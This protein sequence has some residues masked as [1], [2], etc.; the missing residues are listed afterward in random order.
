MDTLEQALEDL[1]LWSTPGRRAELL[2]AAWRSGETNIRTL[3]EAARVT[4]QTVYTDLESCGI[5]PGD[6]R[7]NAQEPRWFAPIVPLFTNEAETEE[8]AWMLLLPEVKLPGDYRPAEPPRDKADEMLTFA[9]QTWRYSRY[10]RVV[11][12]AARD[13][14]ACRLRATR[15]IHRAETAWEALRTA[16]HWAAAHHQWVEAADDARQPLAAWAA[17]AE[18]RRDLESTAELTAFRDGGRDG[19]PADSL[20]PDCDVDQA[21]LVAAD[22][23]ETY[24][25]RLGMARVTLSAQQQDV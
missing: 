22:F 14:Y 13:E 1:R 7:E 24:S 17:A 3:A 9:I 18:A 11:V 25:R 15:A 2:A 16:K 20:I 10:H 23:E 5:D 12:A 4:R 6:D 19:M 21:K 8:E